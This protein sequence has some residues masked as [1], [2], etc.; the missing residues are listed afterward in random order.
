MVAIIFTQTQYS[1]INSLKP[2]GNYAY[3]HVK[4]KKLYILPYSV[5]MCSSDP[6]NKRQLFSYTTLKK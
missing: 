4:I 2:F 6:Y 1:N 3:Q 5:F